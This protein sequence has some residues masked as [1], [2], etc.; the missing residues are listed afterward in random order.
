L[1]LLEESYRLTHRTAEARQAFHQL[2]NRFPESAWVH[3]LIANAYENQAENEK[4]IA[5]YK[6]ALVKDPKLPN[7]NFAIGYLYFQNKDLEQAKS[8]LRK[9]LTVQSCHTLAFYYLAEM[10]RT[11]GDPDLASRDYRRALGCDDRNAKAHTGL[12]IVLA[13]LHRNQEAVREL[14]TAVRL[15]PGDAAPHYRLAVLYR[16]LG[17]K[18]ESEAEYA[19]V[20]E[21][22]ARQNQ[23]PEDPKAK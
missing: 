1:F 15:D 4:A 12:G 13:G 2:N 21:I 11:G 22:H 3:Y 6:V 17:R 8:W 23:V 10:A 20:K 5:E 9:E 18:A 19:R 14:Q 7:A 16:E